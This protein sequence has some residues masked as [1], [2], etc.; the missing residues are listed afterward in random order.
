MATRTLACV[1]LDF[2]IASVEVAGRPG[3]RGNPVI[4]G[5][6]PQKRG[7]V[8]GAS[9]EAMG[10][11]VVPGMLT[12]EALRSCPQAT[13]ISPRPPLYHDK[14]QM[15]LSVLSLYS[16]TIEHSQL[17]CFYLAIPDHDR[18]L[19][20]GLQQ[21]L[22]EQTGLSVSIGVASNKLV[23]HTAAYLHMPEGLQ[24]VSAGQEAAFLAPL[25]IERL[26]VDNKIRATLRQLGL[27]TIGDVAR[28]P[29][30]LL[31]AH[32]GEAGKALLRHAQGK[33]AR[34]IRSTYQRETVE[35][36]HIF[37]H[38][39]NER[40]ALRRWVAYLSA[41]VGQDVRS[42]QEYASALTLT[43]GHLDTEP[44]VLT[45]VL[46]KASNLDHTL[47]QAALHLLASW[48][49]RASVVSLGLEANIFADEPGF[50]LNIFDQTGGDWEEEQLRLDRA[51][52]GINKRYGQGA[53]MTAMLLDDDIL[54]D[55]GKPRRKK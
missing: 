48:N 28:T 54:A 42:H 26:V 45:V 34:T 44:T 36:E 53:V 9:P 16:D 18:D 19:M 29:E 55:M 33:D 47:R 15:V 37:D 41:Q 17:D 51:K 1:L 52:N 20:A 31:V 11:G 30:H 14:A 27:R 13:L 25:P 10:M 38:A 12:W 35:R 5:G 23:A 49:G 43:L 21:Q 40:E 6:D 39:I 50:Q 2:F 4:V 3:L 8:V 7:L 46:P 22:L 32:T 24:I